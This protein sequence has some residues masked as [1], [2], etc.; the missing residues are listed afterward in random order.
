M[1]TGNLGSYR[2]FKDLR[3]STE[4]ALF[5]IDSLL[6]LYSKAEKDARP[7]FPA[8]LVAV[9]EGQGTLR[10]IRDALIRKHSMVTTA[11]D[12]WCRSDV[13]AMSNIV[14]EV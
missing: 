5:L 10:A 9:L 2:Q 12:T 13:P 7:E 6:D 1:E 3:K 8:I 4:P 14:D 11:F